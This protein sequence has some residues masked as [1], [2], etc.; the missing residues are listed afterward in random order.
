MDVREKKGFSFNKYFD[1]FKKKIENITRK[2]I[3]GRI[4]LLVIIVVVVSAV[5]MGVANFVLS[6]RLLL[7]TIKKNMQLQT[8]AY[9]NQLMGRINRTEKM[10]EGVANLLYNN[11]PENPED[12]WASREATIEY[13]TRMEKTAMAVASDNEENVLVFLRLNPQYFRPTDGFY[14]QQKPGQ[15]VV[16]SLPVTDF[17]EHG[18]TDA[19]VE[20]FYKP[21]S[22]HESMWVPSVQNHN[23]EKKLMSYVVPLIKDDYG[24]GVVGIDITIESINELIESI[25]ICNGDYAL[26]LSPDDTLLSSS[27]LPMDFNANQIDDTTLS[28][29]EQSK[30]KV[31]SEPIILKCEGTKY[32]VYSQMLQNGMKVI[33]AAPEKELLKEMWKLPLTIAFIAVFIGIIV[34]F[35]AKGFINRIIGPLLS[36]TESAEAIAEGRYN[37]IIEVK[38]ETKSL[39]EIIQ[40]KRLVESRILNRSRGIEK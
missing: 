24:I 5:G 27:E 15:N 40:E 6:E 35:V 31:F 28:I 16:T 3:R 20:W 39:A 21:L 9:T 25:H 37:T 36:L 23:P 34:I 19:E 26:L 2:T 32:L 17:S 12:L 14:L 4:F 33:V 8:S 29:L 22:T 1:L 10:S 11:L 7:D 13:V 18:I 38:S 30:G